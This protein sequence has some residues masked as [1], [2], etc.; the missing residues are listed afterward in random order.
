MH[1]STDPHVPPLVLNLRARDLADLLLLQRLIEEEGGAS[2][3]ELNAACTDTFAARA[4]EAE[5]LGLPSRLWPCRFTAHPDWHDDYAVAAQDGNV[6]ATLN[7][8]VDSLNDWVRDIEVGKES[9][10]D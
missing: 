6:R 5:A 8:A 4:L 3:A 2:L 1:A 7:E 10:T 9:C